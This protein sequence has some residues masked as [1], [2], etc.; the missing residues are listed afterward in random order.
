MSNGTQ[1]N[2]VTNT[3]EIRNAHNR[4]DITAPN[5]GTTVSVTQPTTQ[6]VQINVPG[7]Q[8][9]RGEAGSSADVS[10]LNTFT[11]SI[12]TQVNSLTAATGSYVL[13]SVTSS[14]LQ[15]YVLSSNT[16]SFV[17]NVQT[18]S[19]L[20]PY[21]LTSVTASMLQP[22]VLNANTGSFIT[23]AQT[24]SMTVLSSSV[25]QTAS[26]I[27][28]TFIS[29]SAAAAGFGSTPIETDPVFTSRSASLATT[30]SN[31]FNGNQTIIGNLQ[32]FGT[33][34]YNYVTASQLDVGTEWI[35]V[36]VAEPGERFGGL[37]VYDSGSVSHQATASLAWD[38]LHNHWV[39]QNASGSTYNGAML[40][41]GPR[42]TGSLGDE[43]ELTRWFV[44]RGDG[45]DHINSTQIFSSGSVHQIT[46]SLTITNNL[47]VSNSI[48]SQT[49]NLYSTNGAVSVD[50]DN[51][52]LRD[53]AGGPSIDWNSRELYDQ[54]NGTSVNWALRALIDTVGSTS[55]DWE[56][57]ALQTPAGYQILWDNDNFYPSPDDS[58]NLGFSDGVTDKRFRRGYFSREVYANEFVGNL[59][60]TASYATQALSASTASL[61]TTASYINPT[62]IS[63]SAAAAGFGSGGSI[64]TSAFATTGS[65]TFNGN[66]T[67]TGSLRVTGS[68]I[69]PSMDSIFGGGE[70][71]DLV[72]TSGTTTL[73]R[74]FFYRNITL[75]T[76][77]INTGNWRLFC[78]NL[79]FS[80]SGAAIVNN[81]GAGSNGSS[82][83]GANGAG[84]SGIGFIGSSQAGGN[85]F[86]PGTAG[87]AA[88]GT[89]TAISTL[90]LGFTS[91]VPGASGKGGNTAA[92]A[93][94]AA[95]ATNAVT[96]IKYISTIPFV[97]HLIRASGVSTFALVQG[98]TGGRGGS[99]GA[100]DVAT[101]TRG[102]GGGG[103]GAG[104]VVV[105]AK[106]IN[107]TNAVAPVFSAQG[108]AGGNGGSTSTADVAGGGGG[109]GGSGGYIIVVYKELI[110]G[111]LVGAL[112]ASGGAGGNGGSGGVSGAAITGG[113]GGGAGGGGR[114]VLINVSTGL[115]THVLGTNG[116]NG[117]AATGTAGGAGA[118]SSVTID[119]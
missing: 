58:V 31:T 53:P 76:S 118:T 89:A 36:N 106:T 15:P 19:M 54:N 2:V 90:T 46:G 21:V 51:K 64:N 14:M 47:F 68:S 63:A 18:A 108:G 94:G 74:D 7:P 99:S 91:N 38:S 1:I 107:I 39:Y 82:A 81:G 86:G 60:G 37:K 84:V 50:W 75:G 9:I 105:F 110:G 35:S 73:T 104:S 42:N 11:A 66:Q 17:T 48:N 6:V 103:G 43:P 96:N 32:V 102:G 28:P 8:G 13:T 85:G 95:G 114:I 98:G 115:V 100:S 3:V 44:T 101:P 10:S 79:T 45:G 72:S 56:G 59:A 119:L 4:I 34:S 12:Q 16:S 97:D 87:P 25:A 55:I 93:G 113:N 65:N 52:F 33:A 70:D 83:G 27:S 61:A 80:G 62:F 30:G 23:A 77:T 57:R 109:S 24:S 29:A 26:F 20:L 41:S 5:T 92:R 49:R 111:P 117:S 22:Y 112:N 40:I 71:G 78:Q 67:I 88:G 116:A 69:L